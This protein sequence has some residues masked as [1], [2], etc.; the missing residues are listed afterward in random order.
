LNSYEIVQ[1]ALSNISL[2]IA[3]NG[4][5]SPYRN[6]CAELKNLKLYNR[7]IKDEEVSDFF[8]GKNIIVVLP[9]K[10][11]TQSGIIPIAMHYGLPII[12]S[13]V[14]GISEQIIDNQTG[15]LTTPNDVN[16][17]A[18]KMIFLANNS[19]I[20][21]MLSKNS[22]NEIRKTSWD[23]QALKLLNFIEKE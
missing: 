10:T 6:K 15:I 4:D 16:D 1:N 23:N 5:F 18:N 2:T 7:W 8:N 11:A 3:G 21:E 22:Q 13:N 20:R 17:L 9:Y 12:A 19:Q 14:G